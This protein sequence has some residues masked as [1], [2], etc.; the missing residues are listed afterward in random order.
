MHISKESNFASEKE[1]VQTFL[2]G[3]NTCE[4][5][6]NSSIKPLHDEIR[7]IKFESWPDI[8]GQ[9]FKGRIDYLS[10]KDFTVI[11]T[12]FSGGAFKSMKVNTESLITELQ[13]CIDNKKAIADAKKAQDDATYTEKVNIN[14][15][16][17][18]QGGVNG[19]DYKYVTK[20]RQP[21][22]KNAVDAEKTA[23]TNLDTDPNFH[24]SG[25]T[26][27]STSSQAA[28][29]ESNNNDSQRAT[30]LAKENS[31][32]T[33]YY[34]GQAYHRNPQTGEV[35]G[36]P[37]TVQVEREVTYVKNAD[38]EYR[39]VVN[40]FTRDS[41]GNKVGY[42]GNMPMPGELTSTSYDWNQVCN[43]EMRTATVDGVTFE[44][45]CAVYKDS[46]EMAFVPPNV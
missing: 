40:E 17:S 21:A 16:L 9:T 26:S 45:P 34:E 14:Q 25:A 36:E 2:D 19:P 15:G 35:Y 5:T 12:D 33:I 18:Y 43:V 8:A 29:E 7:S 11:E 3:L 1:V 13:N 28:I 6:F 38:G 42:D 37:Y 22:Y 44:Y 30:E 4:S 10:D 41:Q 20:Y 46:G 23:T 32:Y 27:G 31:H 24:F 39:V